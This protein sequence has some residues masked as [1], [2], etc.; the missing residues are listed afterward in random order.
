MFSAVASDIEAKLVLWDDTL[1]LGIKLP[2]SAGAGLD[3]FVSIASLERAYLYELLL[4]LSAV[5]HPAI[6]DK[7]IFL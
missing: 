4:D 5:N 2:L 3:S 7:T 6:S 1:P